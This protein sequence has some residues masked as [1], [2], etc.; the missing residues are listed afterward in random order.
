MPSTRHRARFAAVSIVVGAIAS[1]ACGAARGGRSPGSA[2]GVD[3]DRVHASDEPELVAWDAALRV[4][5]DKLRRQGVVAVHYE[6]DGC[7]VSLELLPRCIG[8]KNRYVYAASPPASPA[9]TRIV[10]DAA[11][12][13]AQLPL[14]AA[15]VRPLLEARG[16]L[17]IDQ[18]IVGNVAL[19]ADSTITEYDLVGPE[20]KR[21]THVVGAIAVGG[22]AIAAGEPERLEKVDAFASASPN[23][24][25][26][27]EGFAPICDRAKA[28]GIELSGCSVPLRVV[29]VPIGG[30]AAEASSG[31]RATVTC[32][33][34]TVLD[35]SRC[36]TDR[37]CS[38]SAD[39]GCAPVEPRLFDQSA[40]ERVVRE[41][42]G[43]VK[44]KCWE[45][46]SGSVRRVNVGVSTRIDKQGRVLQADARLLDSEGSND[47]ALAV[48][49]CVGSEVTS[50]QFPEPDV[51]KSF[52]LPFHFIRQ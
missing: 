52:T 8:P 37:A 31:R 45:A 29:L 22:F 12:L 36:V 40:I 47:V 17:R 39:A 18:R 15:N 35:G 10:R 27:R 9:A 43:A 16:G 14:G 33:A 13:Y 19:P 28:E 21:A 51:E 23:E 3:C 24:A 34:G 25:G 30:R 26:V 4:R 41:H 48:A 5:L 38:T 6:S 32:P 7:D 2:S 46:A 49:R 44:R 1:G 42:Q 20:C 50:W 11:A